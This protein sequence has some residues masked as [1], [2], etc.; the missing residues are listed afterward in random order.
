MAGE[1]TL[2]KVEVTVLGAS[3]E[4]S[5][6]IEAYLRKGSEGPFGTYWVKDAIKALLERDPVDA[7]NGLEFLSS[8]FEARAKLIL[9]GK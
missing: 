4:T 7:A 8:W 3:L 1:S 5:A 2:G 9:D 6:G